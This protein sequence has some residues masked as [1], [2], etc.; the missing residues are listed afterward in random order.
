[1]VVLIVVVIIIGDCP[2]ALE[3]FADRYI[4]VGRR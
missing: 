2:R 1:M 3:A 4:E